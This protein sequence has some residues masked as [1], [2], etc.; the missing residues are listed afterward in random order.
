MQSTLVPAAVALVALGAALRP[1]PPAR[2]AETVTYTY[3]AQGRLVRVERSGPATPGQ[4]VVYD[5]D[6]AD[7]R[8]RKQ[9]TGA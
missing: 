8:T 5:H 1:G 3:D 6:R 9:T 7:N 4:T 2:A